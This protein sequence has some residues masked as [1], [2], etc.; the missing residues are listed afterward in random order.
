MDDAA[1]VDF[2][3]C[4]CGEEGV[5]V[6]PVRFKMTR[7]KTWYW[8]RKVLKDA[9]VPLEIEPLWPQWLLIL[10]GSS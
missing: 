10:C 8:P 7:Q 2:F 6:G 9:F 5:M 1:K 4:R 3:F